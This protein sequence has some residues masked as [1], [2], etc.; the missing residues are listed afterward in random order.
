MLGL[1]RGGQGVRLVRGVGGGRG[2]GGGGGP[3][4]HVRP[5]VAARVARLSRR[6]AV[7]PEG[8]GSVAVLPVAGRVGH[9]IRA[10]SMELLR[11]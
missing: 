5:G 9:S 6:V 3:V 1:S 11:L 2:G 4:A 8:S 10:A 7:H